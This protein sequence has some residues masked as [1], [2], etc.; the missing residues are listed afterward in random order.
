MSSNSEYYHIKKHT[1]SRYRLSGLHASIST[2]ICNEDFNQSTGE[3][4]P[5]LQCFV[6]R[7]AA[8][9]ERLQYIYFN[10]VLLLRAVARIGP[11][12]SA[13]DYCGT[14]THEGDAE[15]LA[16]LTRVIDIAKT[17]G[18]FDETSLFNGENANVRPFTFKSRPFISGIDL[19]IF[20]WLFRL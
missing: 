14:G 10:T 19:D 5:N 15:T 13:Y 1:S 9:P 6:D 17:V 3:W 8:Y 11:Y 12:L 16:K 20:I 7:I 2:H 4:G 18:K